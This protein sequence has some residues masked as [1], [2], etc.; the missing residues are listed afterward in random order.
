MASIRR[1]AGRT[2][3]GIADRCREIGLVVEI[4]GART[5]QSRYLTVRAP[6][7]L[8]RLVLRVSDHPER[9]RHFAEQADWLVW[10][11]DDPAAVAERIA[12]HF[13]RSPT[14]S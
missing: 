3:A 7:R 14:H 9:A 6:D 11:D 12:R 8:G 13:G 5:T 10:P 4:A 2:A 1:T